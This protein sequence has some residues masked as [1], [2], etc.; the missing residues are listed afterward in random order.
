MYVLIQISYYL[1][2]DLFVNRRTYFYVPIIEECEQE[3]FSDKD[4]RNC[5]KEH[6]VRNFYLKF[7]WDELC[8][9]ISLLRL[10]G[11]EQIIDLRHFQKNLAFHNIN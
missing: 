4:E 8:T 5:K 11:T 9:F 2:I 1:C 6:Q 3:E 7:K 10:L